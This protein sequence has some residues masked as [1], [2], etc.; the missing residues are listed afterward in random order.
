MGSVFVQVFH[1]NTLANSGNA[2]LTN[3]TQ[4]TSG[5]TQTLFQPVNL[6]VAILGQNSGQYA[7]S[8]DAA[9]YFHFVAD[10]RLGIV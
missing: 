4:F 10:A 6:S 2:A 5:E 8:A 3:W 9:I 1:I 7:T